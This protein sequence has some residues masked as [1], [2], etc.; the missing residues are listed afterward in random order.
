MFQCTEFEDWRKLLWKFTNLS[1]DERR[2][3][4]WICPTLE[5]L[6]IIQRQLQNHGIRNILSIGCGSGFFEWILKESCG[7]R[8]SGLELDNSWWTSAYAPATFIPLHFTQTPIT[9]KFLKEC[10]SGENFS[11]LFVYFNNGPAFWE[12]LE[13]FPGDFVLIAGPE[14]GAGIH[15]NPSPYALLSE[16][17]PKVGSWLQEAKLDVG[18]SVN[19][20]AIYKRVK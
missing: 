15:T 8:V 7:V 19:I 14:A 12:Y 11:L 1:A 3:F 16:N 2:K 4:S 20:I 18:D 10:A 9:E 13:Q 17:A 5:S 6:K